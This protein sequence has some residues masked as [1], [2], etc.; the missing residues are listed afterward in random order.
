MT[1]DTADSLHAPVT[2]LRRPSRLR[3]AV[4]ALRGQPVTPEAIRAEWVAWQIELIALCDKI[5]A[6]ANRQFTRDTRDLDRAL[7]RVAELELE[8]DSG[9]KDESDLALASG[10]S[11]RWALKAALGRRAAA[12]QGR[13]LP[14]IPSMNGDADEHGA[15]AEQA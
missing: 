11:E 1:Q 6:A 12:L 15:E 4:A 10:T 3:Q 14:P 9:Y 13:T 7:K 2:P 5:A 8:Q